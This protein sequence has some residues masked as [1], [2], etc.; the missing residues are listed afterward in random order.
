MAAGL[1]S[2]LAGE[3]AMGVLSHVLE[4]QRGGKAGA[5]ARAGR[6]PGSAGNG[7]GYAPTHALGALLHPLHGGGRCLSDIRVLRRDGLF[8]GDALLS[9]DALA[10]GC[11]G[12]RVRGCAAGERVA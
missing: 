6:V 9:A 1:L 10:A 7:C 8:H 11:G 2:H 4:L 12:A 5:T 3:F